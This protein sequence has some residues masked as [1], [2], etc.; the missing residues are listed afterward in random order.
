MAAEAQRAPLVREQ[1]NLPAKR[2]PRAAPDKSNLSTAG[3]ALMKRATTGPAPFDVR[4]MVAR[5]AAIRATWPEDKMQV[6][7]SVPFEHEVMAI[8]N[9]DSRPMFQEGEV[10]V[11]DTRQGLPEH[12]AIFVIQSFRKRGP[13][14]DSKVDVIR[15]L[16]RTC[17]GRLPESTRLA[18]GDSLDCW[19]IHPLNYGLPPGSIGGIPRIFCSDGPF[20]DSMYYY[21]CTKLAGRVV[22]IYAPSGAIGGAA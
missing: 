4:A 11:F 13:Q 22:G 8:P 14:D 19:Y 2:A 5:Q 6:F 7:T 10:V 9:G 12:G 15:Y 21:L 3:A 18:S 16:G 20:T 17:K 1:T